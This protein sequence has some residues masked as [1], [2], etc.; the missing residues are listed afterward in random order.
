[1]LQCLEALLIHSLCD[2]A[3]LRLVLLEAGTALSCDDGADV[4]VVH[5]TFR[6]AVQVFH[7]GTEVG[8]GSAWLEAVHGCYSLPFLGLDVCSDL[9]WVRHLAQFLYGLQ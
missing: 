2:A 5:F 4:D 6:C 9:R 7:G 8:K 1:M 3:S